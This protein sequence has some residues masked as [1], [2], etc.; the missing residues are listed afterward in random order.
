MAMINRSVMPD[1]DLEAGGRIEPNSADCQARMSGFGDYVDCLV[2]A[3]RRC[4]CALTFGAGALCRHSARFQIAL[5]SESVKS[6]FVL[7]D[8]NP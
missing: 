3:S 6:V 5:R 7:E 8:V 2:D 4:H 1:Y